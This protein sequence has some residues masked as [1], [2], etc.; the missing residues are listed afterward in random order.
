[1]PCR[2]DGFFF[3]NDDSGVVAVNDDRSSDISQDFQQE[4]WNIIMWK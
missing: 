2:Q 4:K 3:E 1:M